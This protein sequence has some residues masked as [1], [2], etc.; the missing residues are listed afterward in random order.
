[1]IWTTVSSSSYTWPQDYKMLRGICLHPTS[2][3]QTQA[4]WVPGPNPGLRCRHCHEPIRSCPSLGL[5]HTLSHR[6]SSVWLW[7]KG[8]HLVKAEPMGFHPVGPQHSHRSPVNCL[9]APSCKAEVG[10]AGQGVR[11]QW[12]KEGSYLEVYL[13]FLP[14]PWP[15]A[16]PHLA[17]GSSEP[18]LA[19]IP[20]M[21]R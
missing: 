6:V 4:P 8:R 21:D 13:P 17:W 15:K 1:M 9:P 20:V 14:H 16:S 19:H 5:C 7:P 3:P 18:V 12:G 10:E 11:G 2:T